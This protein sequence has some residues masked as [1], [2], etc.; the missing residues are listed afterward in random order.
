MTRSQ[1]ATL[2]PHGILNKQHATNPWSSKRTN[3]NNNNK[4]H[5]HSSSPQQRKNTSFERE[6]SKTHT[7]PH[8]R[9]STPRTALAQQAPLS[10]C[11]SL[12]C[13]RPL[14]P[15]PTWLPLHWNSALMCVLCTTNCGSPTAMAAW[16]GATTALVVAALT[17]T[18]DLGERSSGRGGGKKRIVRR[19]EDRGGGADHK[20]EKNKKKHNQQQKKARGASKADRCDKRW[21]PRKTT[22]RDRVHRAR[23]VCDTTRSESQRCMLDKHTKNMHEPDYKKKKK[24]KKKKS[25][26]RT[27][28]A[29]G[30]G[31]APRRWTT[32]RR[33]PESGWSA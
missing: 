1:K 4:K 10:R 21:K 17:L 5:R 14:P 18:S 28:W 29:A 2:S 32:C 16:G 15:P 27:S 3:N 7:H 12:L 8:T 9:Q 6:K 20:A 30:I 23:R 33:A 13:F 25:Q 26:E 11:S 19:Q 22:P 24:K 31:R